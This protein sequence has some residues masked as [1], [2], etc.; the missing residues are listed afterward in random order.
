MRN[1]AIIGLV[2]ILVFGMSLSSGVAPS[3]AG[4][5]APQADTQ[6]YIPLIMLNSNSGVRIVVD[7]HNTD[8]SQ[9]PDYWIGQAKQFVV[10]YAHTSH[11]SQI[12]T[13]LEW[14]EAR[15][16]K[17]HVDIHENGTVVQPDDTTAL[18]IY[19]GNNYDGN[20]Y[21]TPDLYWETSDGINHTNSVANTGWFDFSLWTWCGQMSYYDDTQIQSYLDTM[22]QFESNHPGMRF[23]YYTGHTDGTGAGE[24]LWR[25]NDMVRQYV[26]QNNKV[27][28]DFADIETYTPTGAGPYLNDGDSYCEWCANWC[29]THP[30]NFECQDLPPEGSCA[31]THSLAC[32]LKGQ[33]FWWLMAR[34]AG[35]DGTP[36]K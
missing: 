4:G 9:I 7:H 29:S 27:L 18:R 34:L 26:Q 13:G 22:A 32:T 20:T 6:I 2:F 8:V 16:S 15:N 31:H 24:A 19:D 28:F 36:V 14:L 33:A 23:I 3:A 25:H 17:Y 10:H 12:L 30:S 21:I 11:G 1:K 5:R 35:W